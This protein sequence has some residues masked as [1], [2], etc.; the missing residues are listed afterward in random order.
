MAVGMAWRE[1]GGSSV[2]VV[3]LLLGLALW[4]G[5]EPGP[6]AVAWWSKQGDGSER[7]GA[8]RLR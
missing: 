1:G 4:A 3:A 5:E 7:G 6:R 8:A 2:R